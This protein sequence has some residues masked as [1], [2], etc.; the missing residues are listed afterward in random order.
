MKKKLYSIHRTLSLIIAIPV[1]L[2]AVSGFMHPLMTNIRPAV[3][4]QRLVP[5]QVDSSRL[6]MSLQTALQLNHIDSFSNFRL[7]HIDTTWFY[8]VQVTENKTPVYLSA[9]NGKVLTAGDWLYAQYL[10][11]QFLEG[12]QF[13][14]T[15]LVSQEMI[16]VPV[17]EGAMHDCCDAATNCVLKNN[18]GSKV[19]GVS[20]L[21]AFDD[22]YKYINRL[23]PVYKVAFDR[24]DGIR[25]YVET[26]QDRFAFAMDNKRAAFDIVFRWL[27][28]WAWLDFTGKGRLVV[29][30]LVALLA[31]TTTLLGIYIFFTTRSK[32]AK[33]NTLVKARRRH[34]FTSIAAATFTLLWT[35][36]GAYHA[37]AKFREDNRDQFFIE[38]TFHTADA[39]LD[40]AKLQEAVQHPVT[41][42]SMVKINN[43]QY[44]QVSTGHHMA[45]HTADMMKDKSVAPSAVSYVNTQTYVVLP[46]G[47]E[48]YARYMAT[49][50]SK[51]SPSSI[52]GTAVVTKF[53]DEYNFTDKR[54][55][56]WK[57][58]YKEHHNERLYVETTSGK[59][60]SRVDDTD[61]P[62]GYSFSVF[63]K[64]H[65]MD[66]GGKTARDI[67]TM[68]WALVQV[69]M[70][71]VG[72]ILYFRARKRKINRQQQTVE[73]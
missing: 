4:T 48:E 14:K 63:H 18:K 41:N 62:E 35:F 57:I 28:T 6:H 64:H 69:L 20:Q 61:I 54:L 50:F 45:A 25:I 27:H 1:L 68:F 24:E 52:T 38:N 21:T 11:K 59:L 70:V 5:E 71:A 32:N 37:L 73:I 51:N 33:G 46:Q 12:Q 22:E 10:A 53:T 56:V 2:W 16:P 3:T 15:V 7:I 65:F 43:E 13:N 72:L 30:S 34:R 36:S 19:T 55:P 42:I 17:S 58:S 49:R 23:L 31:L 60:A 29:I 67:S 26:T 66:W 8:Q 40:L 47:D 44:W 39:D 9:V